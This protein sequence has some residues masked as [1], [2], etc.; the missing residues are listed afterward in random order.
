M[1]TII[2]IF[3]EHYNKMNNNLVICVGIDR[4][5]ENTRELEMEMNY[6]ICVWGDKYGFIILLIDII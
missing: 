1:E 2:E 6:F 5:E 4:L 3:V